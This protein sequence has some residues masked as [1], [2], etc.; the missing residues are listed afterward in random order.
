[1]LLLSPGLTQSDTTAFCLQPTCIDTNPGSNGNQTFNCAQTLGT[2]TNGMLFNPSTALATPP[3]AATCCLVSGQA[4]RAMAH[5][6]VH[7]PLLVTSVSSS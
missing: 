7:A 2:A 3:S 6:A 4:W 1:M 5:T